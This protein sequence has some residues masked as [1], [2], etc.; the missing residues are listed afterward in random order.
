MEIWKPKISVKC[1][2]L[3]LLLQVSY[4]FKAFTKALNVLQLSK[5]NQ[6]FI[7]IFTLLQVWECM[8]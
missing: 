3:L 1:L 6:T 4:I 7:V 8:G 5:E 2:I